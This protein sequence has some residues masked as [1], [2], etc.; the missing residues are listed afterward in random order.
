MILDWDNIG[1][2]EMCYRVGK[3]MTNKMINSIEVRASPSL[4]GYHVYVIFFGYVDRFLI[5]SYR[6]DYWDDPR[7]LIMDMLNKNNLTR[8]S[9]FTTKILNKMGVT[10]RL[11][12]IPIFKYLQTNP[13]S[14]KWSIKNYTPQ[15]L[16][17]RQS[18][19]LSSARVAC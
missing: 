9:L 14:G 7:K 18:L 2:N 13:M 10:L 11:K 6:I 8:E 3:I 19:L 5:Y 1:Y 15:S 16:A 17:S 4:D 12:E